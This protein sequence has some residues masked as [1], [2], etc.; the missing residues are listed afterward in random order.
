[1]FISIL[2]FELLYQSK[3]KENYIYFF[4]LFILCF[5]FSYFEVELD[6]GFGK[7]KLNSPTV[8]TYNFTL[9]TALFMFVT[10]A[11]MSKPIYRDSIHKIEPLIQTNP[12]IKWQYLGAKF[13]GSFIILCF[14]YSGSLFGFILTDIISEMNSDKMLPF[15]F[16]NYIHIFLVFLLP[17]LFFTGSLFFFSGTTSKNMMVVYL[18]GV[19]LL[20]I[21]LVLLQYL[22]HLSNP[23]IAAIAD[24]FGIITFQVYSKYWSIKQQNLSLIPLDGIVLYNRIIWISLGLFLLFINYL[25]YN[26]SHKIRSSKEKSNSKEFISTKNYVPNS[27]VI[28]V[29]ERTQINWRSKIKKY[30]AISVFH[31]TTIISS[32]PFLIILF[33]SISFFLFSV[34]TN[35]GTYQSTP[36]PSTYIILEKIVSV[37]IF[38]VCFVIFYSG[39]LIWKDKDTGLLEIINTMPSIQLS[40]I[41]SKLL[42]LITCGTVAVW[43]ITVLGVSLQLIKG[44]TNI[45]VWLYFYWTLFNMILPIALFSIISIAIHL[46]LNN[47]YL[48]NVI[49][50]FL[51]G[52]IYLL[53]QFNIN[54]GLFQLGNI[55]LASYSE[56]AG[57]PSSSIVRLLLYYINWISIASMILVLSIRVNELRANKEKKDSI[58]N[59][60]KKF[61]RNYQKASLV[62]VTIFFLSFSIIIYNTVILND[63]RTNEA[64]DYEK[65][66]YEKILGKYKHSNQ[67]KIKNISLSVDFYPQERIFDASGIFLLKNTT[68]EI[69]DNVQVQLNTGNSIKWNKTDLVAKCDSIQSY[70]EFGFLIFHLKKPLMP[71]DSVSLNFSFS[72][73]ERGFQEKGLNHDFVGDYINLSKNYFPSI[74]Y[75]ES[76]ELNTSRS[77]SKYK[78]GNKKALEKDQGSNNIYGHDA[79][80]VNFEAVLSVPKGYTAL[81][82]GNLV[83]KSLKD[84]RQ[85]FQYKMP[86]E[87]INYYNIVVGKFNKKEKLIEIDGRNILLEV[88]HE[89]SHTLNLDRILLALEESIIYYSNSFDVYPLSQIRIVEQPNFRKGAKSF[90]GMI[91]ISEDIGFMV[92]VQN[93]PVDPIYST[94]AHEVAHQW[95]GHLV[96]PEDKPGHTLLTEVLSQYSAMILMMDV[97]SSEY[98]KRYLEINHNSYHRLKSISKGKESALIDDSSLGFVPYHKGLIGMHYLQR[99]LGKDAINQVLV[100]FIEDRNYTSY[101]YSTAEDFVNYIE[102]VTPDSV[103]TK[104]NELFRRNVLYEN[105]IKQAILSGN[106]E[107]HY[108]ISLEVLG[109]KYVDDGFRN[110]K[111]TP[112]NEWIEISLLKDNQQIYFGKHKIKSG[113]NLINI[114]LS[115][116]PTTAIVDPEF[117]LLDRNLDD[118]LCTVKNMKL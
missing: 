60:I 37:K 113:K 54:F 75:L 2:K 91:I 8:L 71:N 77:R 4:L 95:W 11:I 73:E 89:E 44:L 19:L 83:N 13:M 61:Y 31:F 27:H 22:N 17:N 66:S 86:I 49:M 58:S 90:A 34:F 47:K 116:I 92:D 20:M 63:Y 88:F 69:I 16:Y 106:K 1:M 103:K 115:E 99:L 98:L 24:P 108:T 42:A 56:L 53:P 82:S 84:E 70:D 112:M 100:K 64:I 32:I 46:I 107:E 6:G 41:L 74:G 18:Q 48:G 3:K 39:E 65:A 109:K 12:L 101:S 117:T 29:E 81:T 94:I 111:E 62:L 36:L 104:V 67:P 102:E 78:L 23:N 21:Y 38:L 45:D 52:V 79:D 5:I 57:V 105:S 80:L 114:S 26:F 87:M 43:I 68:N 59:N 76:F 51:L 110:I 35:Q 25:K 50:I 72:Y 40:S 7:L 97:F 93:S 85:I 118:N 28:Y 30:Y 55:S 10:S 14:V 9:L 96:I 33:A 15:Q